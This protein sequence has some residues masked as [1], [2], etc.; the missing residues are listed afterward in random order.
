VREIAEAS[1]R[2]VRLHSVPLDEF[3]QHVPPEWIWL[4]RYLFTEVL[5]GRNAHVTDGV[6]RALGRPPR[7]F[8]DFARAAW[9]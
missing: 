5:D 2:D 1:G 8:S 6:Q 9:R 3:V 4:M 7:D